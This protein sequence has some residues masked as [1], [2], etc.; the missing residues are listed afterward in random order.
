MTDTLRTRLPRALLLALLLT[1]AAAGARE[2]RLQG[3][4]GD[5]ASACPDTID[6]SADPVPAP[7]VGHGARATAV[8]RG[9]K[10]QAGTMVRSS[11][12]TAARPRW[13]SILPG[14]FR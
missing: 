2:V 10:P 4:N 13:H 14:M 5:G 12:E 7:H 3:P 6:A 1:T 9:A 11:G 8:P